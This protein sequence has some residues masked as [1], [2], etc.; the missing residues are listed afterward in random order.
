MQQL[1]FADIFFL[2]TTIS[3]I[4]VA[5]S[6]SALCIY[7]ALVVRDIRKVTR[8]LRNEGV[9]LV[10]DLV[11]L[12]DQLFANKGKFVG[13]ALMAAEFIR[14]FGIPGTKVSPTTKR[15]TRKKKSSRKKT[16]SKSE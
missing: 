10:N 1:F 3:V 4:L 11:S 13:L 2:V 9:E 14:E 15:S 16:S 7:C 12:K 5:A 8:T 6:A